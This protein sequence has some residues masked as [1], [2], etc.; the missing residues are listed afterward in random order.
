MVSLEVVTVPTKIFEGII[1][2]ICVQYLIEDS[3]S[4]SLQLVL[5]NNFPQR[6]LIVAGRHCLVSLIDHFPL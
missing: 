2:A 1:R 3:E 4:G 5:Y 6:S